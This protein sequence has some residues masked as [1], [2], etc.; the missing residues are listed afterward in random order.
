MTKMRVLA[1]F[2]AFE[3]MLTTIAW[4]KTVTPKLCRL[5]MLATHHH[6]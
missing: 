1:I 5:T 6:Q 4:A 2:C 3:A